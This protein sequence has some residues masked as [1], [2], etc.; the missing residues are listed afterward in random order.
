V[1]ALSIGCAT[2]PT[3]PAAQPS[4]A[5]PG[6]TP[7]V[8]ASNR[9]ATPA[10]VT[11][12]SQTTQPTAYATQPPPAAATN[13]PAQPTFD[14]QIEPPRPTFDTATAARF[15]QGVDALNRG[16][17]A[18]GKRAFRDVLDR[19]PKASYAW[20]N[21][22]IIEERE[23]SLSD[24]ERSYRR[25][26]E[27]DPA[28]GTAWDNLTRLFCRTNRCSQ[29]EGELRS[30]IAKTPAALGPR[31]ALVFALIHQNKLEAA[32]T[33]AK[34]VL[35]ADERNVRAMQ[36]LAQVYNREAKF[37]LTRIVLENARAVDTNDAATH[38]ALGLA[39]LQLKQRTQALESFR[40][41]AL[42]KADFAEARNNYGSMLLE[43]QD[44]EAAVREF[45]AAVGAAPDMIMARMNLGSAYRGLQ[46]VQ[47]AI[48]E[49]KLVQKMRPDAADVYFNLAITH[50]D[51]DIPGLDTTERLKTAISYFHQY[52]ERGGRDDRV[53]QYL[54]DANKGI[55]KEERR[56]EREKKDQLKKAAQAQKD[57]A[58]ARAKAA[59]PTSK[60]RDDEASTPR[61]SSGKL[62]QDEK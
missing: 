18:N 56:R 60:L 62:G 57:E 46:Q 36:L 21:L 19:T 30:V 52:K 43:G 9:R 29:I 26:I 23:N 6:D 32:T 5:E 44:F 48:N 15:K 53:E 59:T 42:L 61:R 14:E 22:G 3:A 54:K 51:Q 17:L 31:N 41:A 27:I 39:L 45:E 55:D 38:N 25:A 8:V 1:L 16:D 58:E 37:E 35:K 28:Q 11:A 2:T 47:K 13:A 40:Q 12:D 33:E 10:A 49:F 50:L 24:A 7:D 34:K 20:T 4:L